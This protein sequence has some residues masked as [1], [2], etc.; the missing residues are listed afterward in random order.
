MKETIRYTNVA[1]DN[2]R[3][4]AAMFRKKGTLLWDFN[5]YYST[6]EAIDGIDQI[7]FNYR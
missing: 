5:K 2:V 7:S 3:I 4:G 6:E 1:D